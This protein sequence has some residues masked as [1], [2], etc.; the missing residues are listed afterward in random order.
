MK[1][2]L[3]IFLL[4]IVTVFSSFYFVGCSKKDVIRISEVTRSV[5][6]APFYVALSNGY[7]EDEGMEIELVTSGGSDATMI[8][9]ISGSADIGLMGPETNVYSLAG[10]NEDTPV[11]F[12][13]LTKRDGSFLVSRVDEPDFRWTDLAGKY[14]I[15]GRRGGSPAMNM[16]YVLEKNGF[17][18]GEDVTLDL[19]IAF[20]NT[21]AA[22]EAGTGDYVTM[23][24]PSASDYVAQGKGYI[25][26][27]VGEEAGEV[28]FTCFSATQTFLNAHPDKIEGF[29]R[30]LIRAYNFIM[31]SDMED[32]VEAL[33][34]Y[35]TTTTL[36]NLSASVQSYIDIDAW[37]PT[38]IMK[39]VAFDRLQTIMEGAGTLTERVNFADAVDNS[40]AE[41]VIASL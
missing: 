24:E 37:N 12:A 3:S 7:F 8:A 27:S 6:Y 33:V 19:D 4:L 11:I 32:V 31:S 5:F 18:I 14:I 15:G 21:I 20:T 25:V 16:Q 34:P 29:I 28:P 30:S 22:F 2:Y 10:G 23:F 17:T 1:R 36:A 35:F 39:A 38:L 9:L 40:F 41:R 26:A 13:Q